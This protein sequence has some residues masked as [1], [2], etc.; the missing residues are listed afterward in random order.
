[1]SAQGVRQVMNRFF[2]D[3]DFTN[4]FRVDPV[5]TLNEFDLT[6]DEVVSFKAI[7]PSEIRMPD[8]DVTRRMEVKKIT[9]IEY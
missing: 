3:E 1:M 4:S 5:S 2:N 6:A 9:V 7:D 8:R